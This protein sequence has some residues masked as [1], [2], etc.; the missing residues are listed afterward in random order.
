MSGTLLKLFVTTDCERNWGFRN[1]CTGLSCQASASFTDEERKVRREVE[2]AVVWVCE[3]KLAF[4][5]EWHFTNS[6]KKKD[7]AEGICSFSF[8]SELKICNLLALFF[9]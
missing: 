1:V 2:S 5:S 6:E 7:Y 4:S 9:F 3:G 8:P